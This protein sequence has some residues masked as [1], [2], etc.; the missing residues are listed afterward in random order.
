MLECSSQ[1]FDKYY[2]ALR[3]A[4]NRAARAEG[5]VERGHRGPTKL[6]EQRE[7]WLFDELA[8]RVGVRHRSGKL[9]F[10]LARQQPR[11]QKIA[12]CAKI[13]DLAFE[14]YDLSGN[15]LQNFPR[16]CE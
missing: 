11:K 13:L 9:Q 10:D 15:W 6:R 2:L 16:F 5:F 14:P 4:R 8:F 12:R 1:S 3:L 7:G